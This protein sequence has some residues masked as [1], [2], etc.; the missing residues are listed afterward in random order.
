VGTAGGCGD[1]H[2]F[3]AGP[4]DYHGTM[5]KYFEAKAKLFEGVGATLPRVAVINADDAAGVRLIEHANRSQVMTYGLD[6]GEYRAEGV[7]MRAGETRFLMKTPHGDVAMLSPLTG[8]RQCI[9]SAGSFVCCICARAFSG[10]D[11]FGCGRFATG[12]GAVPGGAGF[13]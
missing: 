1:V 13:A 3:D 2:E 9:Q 6:G 7:T 4:F 5:E 8:R 12:A 10:A 11:C